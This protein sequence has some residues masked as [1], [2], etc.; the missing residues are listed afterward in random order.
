MHKNST[1]HTP[2]IPPC[3]LH[4][5]YSSRKDRYPS[6]HSCSNTLFHLYLTQQFCWPIIYTYFLSSVLQSQSA[7][8]PECQSSDADAW[9]VM[10]LHTVWMKLLEPFQLCY[11]HV[12]NRLLTREPNLVSTSLS[13]SIFGDCNIVLVWV[14]DLV[15]Y[16]CWWGVLS[17][18][19]L[20]GW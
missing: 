5:L 19:I 20:F 2:S 8:G 15:P 1:L 14:L 7:I 10:I 9:H 13:S 12:S 18:L 17:C 16:G 11:S 3:G 4:M 6:L